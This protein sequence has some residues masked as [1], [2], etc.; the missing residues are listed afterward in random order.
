MRNLP[1]RFL[2]IAALILALL[3]ACTA[4]PLPYFNGRTVY[5]ENCVTC[6]GVAGFGD[7]PMAAQL[8]TAPPDLTRLSLENG[9]QFP[10][11][12]V[13]SHIDGY[14]RVEGASGAMPEFGLI[15]LGENILIETGEGV[16]TPTPK[17][18]IAV[19]N[20][21]ESLQIDG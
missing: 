10:R 7:G 13:L 16:V 6:H 18:L 21:I 5:G 4:L 8:P 17:S 20:Y 15:L 1:A 14:A 12:R 19:T 3:S 9:G 2:V 11:N